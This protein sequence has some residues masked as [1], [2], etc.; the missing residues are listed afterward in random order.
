[1]KPIELWQGDCLELM[2]NIPDGSVDLVLTDP[3]YG[4]MKGAALDGWK[5]Q[6]TEWDTAIDPVKIFEQISRVLRQNGKAVLFSQ[7][8]YTSRLITSAIPSLPFAYRAMWY[9]NVHANALLAKSAMVSRYE[10]ICIF[11]KPHDAECTNE[12]RDYFKCVLEFIGAKSC[13]EIN[14]RLGHRKAEHCFY[15]TEGKRA[16]KDA[17]GG[18][19][20][21]TT[22]IGSSQF[23]LC[24]EQTYNEIVSVF[25][26]DKMDGFLPYAELARLNEKYTATFNLWQGGK[27]KSN[28]LEYKKDGNG[29]HP[30]QKPVA[31]LEDL[32]QTYSN[33]GN[34]VL[35]FTM[36]S[37]STG[38]AC[39]NTNRHFIGIELDEGY[40][41]IAKK[42]IEE[43]YDTATSG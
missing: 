1:M 39:V 42:R 33:E 21:H 35:D 11:T 43:A 23:A 4:T 41:N 2:K 12:L 28:V 18:K 30:T 38:V 9:K 36:G 7:E 19:V 6:T 3:P 31:L 16:V 20:D 10:D 40:F 5:N 26:V 37:G 24:T 13:K 25:G 22:R 14:A 34:T 27:S 32:I 8:P 15:V 29:Y 17:M